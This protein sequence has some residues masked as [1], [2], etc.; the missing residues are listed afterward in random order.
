M[1]ILCTI[2]N[3]YLIALFARIILSWFPLEPGTAMASIYQF[4]F[5]ITEPV[6]GPLRRVIPPVGGGGFRLDLSPI[7]VLIGIQI[8]QSAVLG[9]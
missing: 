7:I 8:I 1:Q 2:L 9:C 3:L 5:T 6:L 4:L